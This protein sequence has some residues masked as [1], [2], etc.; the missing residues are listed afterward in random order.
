MFTFYIKHALSSKP[1]NVT[2]WKWFF[3]SGTDLL[4]LD[5]CYLFS[6]YYN[7]YP[8]YIKYIKQQSKYK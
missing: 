3:L 2:E 1:S 8:I 6:V 7:I 4:C 5:S